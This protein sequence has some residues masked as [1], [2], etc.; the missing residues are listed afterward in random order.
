M[1]GKHEEAMNMARF[2]PAGNPASFYAAG[3]QHSYEMP[4]YLHSLGLD[5]YEYQCGRGVSILRGTAER[6]GAE[7]R[8]NDISLSLHAPYFINLASEEEEKVRNSI[9][10]ILESLEAALWLGATR[11]VLH[12]GSARDEKGRTAPLER[13]KKVLRH[14]MKEAD[15]R[16]LL[17]GVS[18]CPEV[19]GKNNQ[20]GSLEEVVE[21]CR[22]D[23]RLI[24]CVDFGHLNAR[25]QGGMRTVG[26]FK[27]ACRVLADGLGEERLR[28][29]HVHF[30]RIE[31]T[32]GGEKQHWTMDDVRF[33][34]DFEPFAEVCAGM[35]L[36][37]VV[38]CESRDTQALDALGMKNTYL[39]ALG[40]LR[41]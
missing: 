20:L 1:D 34:P 28:I 23:D 35:D 2:G 36:H 26:E 39:E 22:I 10:Y 5:A 21:L 7:A 19:M 33:G 25:L 18:L 12:P 24:P 29:L 8:A 6:I 4:A 9:G 38:I 17:N 15:E 11:V 16:S 30:S 31:F 37:P 41:P 27:G 32:A 3:G 13:A 14:A 40:R